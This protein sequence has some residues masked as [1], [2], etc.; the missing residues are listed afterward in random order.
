M[1]RNFN[2]KISIIVPVYNAEL[3]L[4]QCL[5]SIKRQ[6]YHHFEVLLINDGSRDNSKDICLEFVERG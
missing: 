5:D 2:S 4:E 1:E 6:T 3:Y